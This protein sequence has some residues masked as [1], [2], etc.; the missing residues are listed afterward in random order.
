VFYYLRYEIPQ[1]RDRGGAIV[2]MA[3]ILGVDGGYTAQ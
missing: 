3:S 1:M 2:N